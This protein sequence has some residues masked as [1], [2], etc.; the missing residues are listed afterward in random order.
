MTFSTFSDSY[1]WE[2]VTTTF[3]EGY[4]LYGLKL[5][6]QT[7]T[8]V[9]TDKPVWQRELSSLFFFFFFFFFLSFSRQFR[10]FCVS[11]PIV[12]IVGLNRL[13]CCL[14]PPIR[15]AQNVRILFFTLLSL[16]L[17]P[18]IWSFDVGVFVC[19]LLL[20]NKQHCS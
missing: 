14:S 3:H 8:F 9:R 19:L 20:E 2:L 10:L 11:W 18:W 16:V 5:T 1:Q 12:A 15:L 7:W 4:T 6:S 13:L 17:C